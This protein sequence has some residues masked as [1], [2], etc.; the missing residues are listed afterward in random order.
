MGNSQL[1]PQ[2]APSTLHGVPACGR[3]VG[4]PAAG[5]AHAHCGGSTYWQTG[6]PDP[7]AHELHQ[8]RVPSSYQQDSA[9]SAHGDS[10]S[11][12]GE[13]HSLGRGG[14]EQAFVSGSVTL[15]VP[16]W[17]QRAVVR[18]AG[19]GSSP[20][21]QWA[22][23]QVGFGSVGGEVQG[24]PCV[25]GEAGH[26]S[27]APPDPLLPAAPPVAPPVPAEPPVAPP[28]PDVPLSSVLPPQ[29]TASTPAT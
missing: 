27:A 16:S 24:P 25:G 9:S 17:V 2:D 28:P 11:G 19:R 15:H 7:P 18:H 23:S 29:A 12:G 10:A 6:Y 4:Q 20:Q 22:A 5:A 1:G 26:R 3:G 14:W 13:G 21:L 8:Q